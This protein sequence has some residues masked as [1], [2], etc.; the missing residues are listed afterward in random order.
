MVEG[1]KARL[2]RSKGSKARLKRKVGLGNTIPWMIKGSK[3]HLKEVEK[4]RDFSSGLI[5]I[6]R[7]PRLKNS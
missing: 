7:L 5:L 1:L 4:Y 2:K 3:M 6:G